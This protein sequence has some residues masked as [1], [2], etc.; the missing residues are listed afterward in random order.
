MHAAVRYMSL[1][2]AALL[3]ASVSA[4]AQSV[5]SSTQGLMLDLHLN[6]SSIKVEDGTNES[7]AGI[8]ARMA[9]GFTP[10]IS[11]YLGY[12]RARIESA[13]SQLADKYSLGQFDLGMQYNF[14]NSDRAWRPY[15]EAAATR[16]G[17]YAD[18]NDAGT[19][20]KLTTS[21]YGMS[22]GG[23]F[24][25]FFSAPW[26]LNTGLNYTFGSFTHA[27]VDGQS[28]DMDKISATGARLNVGMSWHPMARR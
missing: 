3:A 14:A 26:S 19:T 6:G 18:V 17:M 4:S 7:G 15:V 24:Q 8:G 1:A 5:R 9:W 12:D 22:V 10:R 11:A 23:G 16:R 28:V 13:D 2:A 27:E 25:Y 20:Y 21:G